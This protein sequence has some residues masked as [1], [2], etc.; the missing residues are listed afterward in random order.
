MY[1]ENGEVE[2][3]GDMKNAH[4]PDRDVLDHNKHYFSDF[5]P[6]LWSKYG[7]SPTEIRPFSGP[8]REQVLANQTKIHF[9]SKLYYL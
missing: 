6:E 2:Y 4:R 9:Y 7:L 8:S 3:G 1:G 5:P